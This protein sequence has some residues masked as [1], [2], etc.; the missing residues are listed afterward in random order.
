MKINNTKQT[1]NFIYL[2][3]FIQDKPAALIK[4]FCTVSQRYKKNHV[5]YITRSYNSKN[6]LKGVFSVRQ[7]HNRPTNGNMIDIILNSNS[8]EQPLFGIISF[9]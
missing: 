3:T 4:N 2:L 1:T 9:T 7:T 5:A 6:V 8:I